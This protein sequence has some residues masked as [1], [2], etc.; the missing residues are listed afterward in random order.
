M[1]FL[2]DS[3]ATHNFVDP[4]TAKRLGLQLQ[5]T[6][7]FAIE[8]AD[9]E[10]VARKFCCRSTKLCTDL[11]VVFLGDAQVI[12]GTIWLKSLGST[13]WDFTQK[14]ICF[15]KDGKEVTLQGTFYKE[16]DIIEGKLLIN[17]LQTKGLAYM[18]QFVEGDEGEREL[19]PK[20]LEGIIGEFS[21][22][23]KE[24][25]GLPPLRGFDHHIPLVNSYLSVNARPYRYPFL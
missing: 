1:S 25:Q 22:I 13:L 19:Y 17:L 20:E 16:M 7:S 23:F 6:H 11:L 9:G 3:G 8:E 24:P 21:S 14:T 4:S 5:S 2:V 10:K 18:L 15:W 12:L